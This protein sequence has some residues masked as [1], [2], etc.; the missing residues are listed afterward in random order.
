MITLYGIP[1]AVTLLYFGLAPRIPPKPPLYPQP[2]PSY[3]HHTCEAVEHRL[4]DG[5]GEADDEDQGQDD[6]YVASWTQRQQVLRCRGKG[7]IDVKMVM[8]ECY[9]SPKAKMEQMQ[10]MDLLLIMKFDPL[11]T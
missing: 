4:G 3:P 6:R 1:A 2:Q 7:R 11:P 10:L 8:M 5:V 9:P